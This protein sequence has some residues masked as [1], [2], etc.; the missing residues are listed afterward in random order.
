MQ[1]YIK[2]DRQL[3]WLSQVIAKINRTYVPKKNDDSHTNLYF[4]NLG[5]RITGRWIDRSLITLHDVS[6][7]NSDM[8]ELENLPFP[9]KM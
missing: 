8:E 6:V 5:K 3:H 7:F 4:D 2:T 9:M 1:A